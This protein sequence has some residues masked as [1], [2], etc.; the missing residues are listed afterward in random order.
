MPV[1]WLL[2]RPPGSHWTGNLPISNETPLPNAAVPGRLVRVHRAIVL[3]G[4][5]V[6]GRAVGRHLRSTGW[7]VDLVARTAREP[8][9]D[10]VVA[11]RHD[12]AA[13][14]AVVGDGADLLVD[15][16]CYTSADAEMLLPLLARV[17]ATVVMSARAVYVD[18]TGSHLNSEVPAHFDAPV[19]EQ[20]PTVPPS[21]TADHN[22]REG[23]AACKVAA[24]QI[25]L[26]S[27]RPVT[28]LRASKVHG[29]GSPRPISE[30]FVE[31][32]LS[33]DGALHLAHPEYADHLTA[34]ANIANLVETVATRPQTRILNVADADAPTLADAAQAVARHLDHAWQV[35]MDPSATAHPGWGQ[36][37]PML[38]DTGAAQALG[39]RPATFAGTIGAEIDW[40]TTAAEVR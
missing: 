29:G 13:L 34:A 19:T 2:Q 33:G 9:P 27:G 20:Q 39:H 10:V 25:L 16:L 22:S 26:D 6:V 14:R 38:L 21:R 35:V 37:H 30:F 4:T 32:I 5:G 12:T 8:F 3:G 28:I 24:E 15:C 17:T 7:H 11:D 40:L 31:R 36:R 18:D 1:E 23:Y